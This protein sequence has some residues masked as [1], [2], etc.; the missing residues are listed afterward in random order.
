M[1]RRLAEISISNF[2]TVKLFNT[3]LVLGHILNATHVVKAS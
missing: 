1:S 3:R 2:V